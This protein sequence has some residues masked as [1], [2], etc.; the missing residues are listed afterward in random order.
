LID[1]SVEPEQYVLTESHLLR[2][3]PMIWRRIWFDR[4]TLRPSRLDLYDDA[5]VRVVMSEMLAYDR[6]GKVDVCTAYRIRFFTQDEG[7]MV[8]RL[9][10][11]SLTR[12]LNPKLFEYRVPPEANVVDLDKRP[13]NVVP[14][15]P[16]GDAP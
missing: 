8:L 1:F 6:L 13:V 10:D 3:S 12:K 16:G 11:I 9:S 4:R 15:L 2:F 14:D 5:G 7:Y